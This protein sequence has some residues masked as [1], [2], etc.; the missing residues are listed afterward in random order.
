MYN[1]RNNN[2]RKNGRKIMGEKIYSAPNY[3]RKNGR[4]IMG[5]KIY[6]V[7]PMKG[8]KFKE[9]TVII[10]FFCLRQTVKQDENTSPISSFLLSSCVPHDQAPLNWF[11][12][13]S[14]KEKIMA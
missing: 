6:R 5:E 4:K 1:G 3:G 14:Y 8:N 12:F 10:S 13:F 9:D 2:G 7:H 11:L